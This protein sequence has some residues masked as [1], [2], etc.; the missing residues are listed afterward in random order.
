MMLEPM[1][2]RIV[3]GAVISTDPTFRKSVREVVLTPE[4]RVRLGI[5]ID[6]PFAEISAE[7][8]APL[9][10]SNAELVFLDLGDEPAVGIRFAH[11]LADANPARR[12]IATGPVLSPETLIAA[13]QAGISEYLPKPATAEALGAAL[14]RAERKLG[15]SGGAGTR[16]A[17]RIL[18]FYSAKGGSGCT[19]LAT[20]VAIHLHRLTGKK[21]LLIDLDPELGE[22]ALFLGVEPRF[23]FVD[24][25]RNFHRMDAE[26]LNSYIE[27]HES[28]VHLLS[29]PYQPE[30]SEAISGEQIHKVLHFLKQHYDYL[31]VD[32]SKSL[33]PPT[34]ANLAAAD[35]IYLITNVDLP[36]LRN[37]KRCLPVLQ[38]LSANGAEKVRLVVNRYRPAGPIS[39]EEVEQTLGLK[40][41]RTLSNDYEAVIGAINSGKPLA[42]N[43]SDS[44]FARELKA[45]GAEI[46]GLGGS[47]NVGGRKRARPLWKLFGSR[48]EAW[49]HG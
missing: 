8:I 29:A 19:T 23:N 31:V 26:L 38:G 24:L 46:A 35:E 41:Y 32:S 34:L 20:N 16:R 28:G 14:E 44:R 9:R 22:I 27:K 36:S 10:E 40:P 7:Q 42:L 25:I 5:E 12:L 43:G 48:K 15:I 33:S 21:T 4:G 13:M 47:A 18:S 1:E 17:G 30:P 37:I 2:K 39:L 49:S 6:A 45:M 3:V 11:F